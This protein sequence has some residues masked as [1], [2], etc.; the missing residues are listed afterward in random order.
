MSRMPPSFS[1]GLLCAM[2]AVAA[3][4]SNEAKT[5]ERTRFIEASLST[6]RIVLRP[7][8]P[9]PRSCRKR[10]AAASRRQNCGGAVFPLSEMGNSWHH[11]FDVFADDH[12]PG[13]GVARRGYVA[14]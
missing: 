6:G 1:G 14:V 11:R 2:A 9:S 8:C 3:S 12:D 10:S 7:L 4:P 13:L 5:P